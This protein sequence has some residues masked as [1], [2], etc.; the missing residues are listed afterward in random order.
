M[1]YGLAVN[2]GAR[3]GGGVG[4]GNCVLWENG[5]PYMPI[6]AKEGMKTTNSY[7]LIL[8]LLVGGWVRT[9]MFWVGFRGKGEDA[10]I[11]SNVSWRVLLVRVLGL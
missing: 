6:A 2:F 7:G 10:A 3:G 5:N 11:V 8:C 4:A 9:Y 1:G